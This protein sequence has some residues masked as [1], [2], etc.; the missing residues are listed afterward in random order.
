MM[1]KSKKVFL[2]ILSALLVIVLVLGAVELW[3]YP[4]YRKHMTAVE[5]ND[6]SDDGEVRVMSSNLRCISPTAS[7]LKRLGSHGAPMV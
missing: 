4:H 6:V 3:Y 2:G 7:A 5:V 1:K